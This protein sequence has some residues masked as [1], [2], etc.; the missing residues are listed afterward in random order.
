[1][2]DQVHV[3]LIANAGLLLQYGGVTLMLDGIYGRKGHPFSN[4]KPEIW[5]PDA[6]GR[7]AF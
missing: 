7:A 6:A 4:L 3:T 1:M 5:G 2:A